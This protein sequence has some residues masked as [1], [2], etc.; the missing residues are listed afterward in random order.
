MP[1][2]PERNRTVDLI[3]TMDVLCQLSYRG[4]QTD[5]TIAID[6]VFVNSRSTIRP[7]WNAFCFYV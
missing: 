5:G 1:R 4:W 3:L 6:L 7:N 2:A